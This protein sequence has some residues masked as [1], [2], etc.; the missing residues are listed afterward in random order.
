MAAAKQAPYVR[1]SQDIRDNQKTF[2]F[3]WDA[4]VYSVVGIF[5]LLAILAYLFTGSP[6]H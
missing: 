2:Q 1:G 4:T 5:I 3:F 6:A